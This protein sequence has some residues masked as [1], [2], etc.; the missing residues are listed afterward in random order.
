MSNSE[1]LK[2]VLIVIQEDGKIEITTKEKDVVVLVK[3]PNGAEVA[4][5]QDEKRVL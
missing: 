3:Y 4:V 5:F 1:A 2:K